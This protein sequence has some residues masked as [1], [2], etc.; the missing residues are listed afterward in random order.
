MICL[1][2]EALTSSMRPPPAAKTQF[3]LSPGRVARVSE[4]RGSLGRDSAPTLTRREKRPA[5]GRERLWSDDLC[6][7]CGGWLVHPV[8]PLH[9]KARNGAWKDGRLLLCKTHQTTLFSICSLGPITSDFNIAAI[10]RVAG[11]GGTAGVC[12]NGGDE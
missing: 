4:R 1:F 2:T 11:A 10:Q 6:E 5:S 7:C 8:L 3:E 12:V 9:R